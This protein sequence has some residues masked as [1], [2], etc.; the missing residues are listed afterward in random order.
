M[1]FF[2]KTVL[3]G[4]GVF[5]PQEVIGKENIPEGAAVVVCNHYRNIDC[6][7]LKKIFRENSFFLAKEELFKTKIVGGF[8]K[9][10]GAIPVNRENPSL[11]TLYKATKVLKDGA[12]L[13]IFPEGTRN[14]TKERLLPIKTGSAV[15]AVKSKCPILPVMMLKKAK[16]FRKTR[17]I[18]GKPIY[19]EGYYDKKLGEKEIAELDEIVTNAMLSEQDKLARIIEERKLKKVK[20][21][22]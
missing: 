7:F 21:N 16:V 9:S 20:K 22:K 19:L 18:I 14:K 1:N 15:F 8:I 2:K 11:S 13:V 4:F 5:Y 12:K 17:L 3:G 10:F 6:A